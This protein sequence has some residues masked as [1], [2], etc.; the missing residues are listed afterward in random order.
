M[1]IGAIIGAVIFVS[2]TAYQYVQAQAAKKKQEAAVYKL[3]TPISASNMQKDIGD[4][5]FNRSITFS[6]QP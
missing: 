1:G 3:Q 6:K 5:C 2:S 4:H